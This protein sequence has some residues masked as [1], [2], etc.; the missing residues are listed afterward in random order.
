MSGCYYM[1][2]L[3]FLSE[4]SRVCYVVVFFVFF[5]SRRRHTR[6]A[7][8]TGVQTC[9]LPISRR[10]A[11]ADRVLR[12]R[13]LRAPEG[14]HAVAAAERAA[15]G[16][17]AARCRSGLRPPETCVV[18]G[19][20]SLSGSTL[21]GNRRQSTGTAPG[22]TSDHVRR[23]A[24]PTDCTR[25]R[26]RQSASSGTSRTNSTRAPGA[27][28]AQATAAFHCCTGVRVNP[29]STVGPRACS[30]FGSPTAPPHV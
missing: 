21:S 8:V 12:Q 28:A 14:D 30:R 16:D 3:R 15:G 6:C 25:V 1:F 29:N 27:A 7:L 4:L 20:A 18:A 13:Q 5:S 24:T 2:L 22:H 19:A 9:A 26:C 23:L 17:P 11:G 10:H